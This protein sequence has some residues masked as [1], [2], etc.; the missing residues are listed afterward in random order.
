MDSRHN[1][2]FLAFLDLAVFDIVADNVIANDKGYEVDPM[3]DFTVDEIRQAEE[4][5]R[6]ISNRYKMLKGSNDNDVAWSYVNSQLDW[7]KNLDS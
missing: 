3:Y 1:R 2:I 6:W 7:L 4:D 5:R